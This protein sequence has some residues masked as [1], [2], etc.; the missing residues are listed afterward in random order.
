MTRAHEWTHRRG[1]SKPVAA[2]QFVDVHDV[3]DASPNDYAQ[4]AQRI[5]RL[6]A[7]CKEKRI[8]MIFCVVAS[9]KDDDTKEDVTFALNERVVSVLTRLSGGNAQALCFYEDCLADSRGK[10]HARDVFETVEA[11]EEV[12]QEVFVNEAKRAIEKCDA[13]MH[14]FEREVVESGV[15]VDENELRLG[16]LGEM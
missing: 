16:R 6:K 10:R 1:T 4:C 15:V 7:R 11:T 14:A 3:I 13:V 2:I 8:G 9:Q 12:K 5:E